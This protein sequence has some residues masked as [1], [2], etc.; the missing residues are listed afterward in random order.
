MKDDRKTKKQLINELKDLRLECLKIVELE[1]LEIERKKT[2]EEL[3]RSEEKNRSLL[4]AIPDLMFRLSKDG[5]FM[6]I[7]PAKDFTLWMHPSELIGKD[8]YGVFDK[9]IAEQFMH[10]VKLAVVTG[11]TQIFQ[12]RLVINGKTH[13]YEARIIVSEGEEV[14][15]VV[16]DFTEQRQAEKLAETDPL[17]SIYNRRK[18]SELLDQEITRVERY[19]RFLSVVLLD[20]DHFKKVNDIYGHDVGDYVLKRMT[21]LIR[22]DIRITD[23]LARYGGEEFVIIL[24]ETNIEGARM[25]IERMRK[26]IEEASFDKVGHITI[27]AGIADFKE[28]DNGKSLVKRADEALYLAKR[29][30]RNRVSVL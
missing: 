16:R 24:P 2:E 9:K 7:I 27:S 1:S 17:T 3:R 20:I 13:H 26:L 5:I 22:K 11:E 21:K 14:L 28:H 15:A 23:T 25:Q 29:G 19:H 12:Y 30:G 8:V 4:I 6:E 18:F 10:G